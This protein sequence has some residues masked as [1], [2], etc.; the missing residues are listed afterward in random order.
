MDSGFKGILNLTEAP[1]VYACL[2]SV[3]KSKVYKSATSAN[4]I[5]LLQN[6]CLIKKT[7]N[8]SSL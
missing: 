6:F 1:G 4:W 3:R 2:Y 7:T 5:K 8:E